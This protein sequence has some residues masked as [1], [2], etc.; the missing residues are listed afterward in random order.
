MTDQFL[1]TTRPRLRTALALLLLL[2]TPATAEDGSRDPAEGFQGYLDR[3]VA[4]FDV[5]GAAVTVV[6]VSS[7]PRVFVSGVRGLNDQLPVTPDTSFNIASV[8]KGMTA[9]LANY[10]SHD[11]GINGLMID[12]QRLPGTPTLN[13]FLFRWGND[14]QPY[15]NDL[16]SPDD[17]WPWAPDPIVIFD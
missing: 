2:T 13:D 11:K 16:N 14:S 3:L 9:T 15:G 10:T 8:T 7:S 17:D 6:G 1:G 12:V 5:P 4:D